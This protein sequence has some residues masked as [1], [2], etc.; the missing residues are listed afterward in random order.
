MLPARAQSPVAHPD[1]T[2]IWQLDTTA[3]ETPAEKAAGMVSGT[4]TIVRESE[5]FAI[6][7]S[8]KDA[9]PAHVGLG[10]PAMTWTERFPLDGG[11][12]Q[13]RPGYATRLSWDGPVLVITRNSI[14]T[15]TGGGPSRTMNVVERWNVDATGK[16][17]TRT[18][19]T[20][21]EGNEPI[22]MRFVY[23]RAQ[24]PP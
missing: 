4:L 15:Q 2:G 8:I 12:G 5:T 6:T 21:L 20:T 16:I 23:N 9:R 14:T 19:T 7:T 17:M 10:A 3:F 18:T 1:F 24:S 22:G 13:T 11:V